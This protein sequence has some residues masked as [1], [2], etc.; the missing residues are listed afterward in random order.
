MLIDVPPRTPSRV[1]RY[2][3]MATPDSPSG[4]AKV[5][6]GPTILASNCESREREASMPLIITS[7]PVV[8]RS[9]VTSACWK[10]T[11]AASP[12]PGVDRTV[13]SS[14]LVSVIG[15]PTE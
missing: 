10:S 13:C 7:V 5:P 6:D 15:A 3:P 9:V 14:R 4:V 12:T 1:A 2:F 8:L 11:G